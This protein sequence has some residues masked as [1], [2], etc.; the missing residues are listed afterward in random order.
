MSRIKRIKK[1]LILEL[2]P[3]VLKIKDNSILHK[4]HNQFDGLDETHL[5]VEIKSKIFNNI[6]KIES[7]RLINSIIQEEYKKGL[8]SLVIKI[9]N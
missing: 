4:G 3:S 8:H 1:L 6:T 5:Y 7:H 9:I 2:N